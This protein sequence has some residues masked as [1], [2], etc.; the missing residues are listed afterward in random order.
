MGAVVV[1][2]VHRGP[3]RGWWRRGASRCNSTV[4][5]TPVVGTS[6]AA[7]PCH[8]PPASARGHQALPATQEHVCRRATHHRVAQECLHVGVALHEPHTCSEHVR[9]VQQRLAVAALTPAML[10]TTTRSVASP[11][12]STPPTPSA[13]APSPTSAASPC[14][15]PSR[16]TPSSLPPSRPPTGPTSARPRSR[17]RCRRR[18]PS[19]ATRR[20]RSTAAATS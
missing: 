13:T 19:T 15:S 10:S 17:S 16:S 18:D 3:A 11:S 5:S 14:P 2:V 4:V 6:L 12:S 9:G 7:R 20:S 1:R 8:V